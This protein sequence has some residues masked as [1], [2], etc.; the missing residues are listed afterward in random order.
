MQFRAL[1]KSGFEVPVVSF[2]AWAIGGWM[3]GGADDDDAVRAI[4]RGIDLGITCIDTAPMY[5][6]G[7]SERLV[8]KAIAGRRDE[9]IVATKCGLRWDLEEGEFFFKTAYPDGTPT[10]AYKNLRPDSIRHECEQS[11]ERLGVDMIDLYQ[12]HW[13]EKGANLEDT[14][15]ALN[16][17]QAE[18]K[19]RAFGVSNFTPEM[20]AECLR[21]G[22]IVSDQPPYSPLRRD[23][24]RDVLPF[25]AENDLAVLV[26][27]PLD[28]GLMTGKVTLDREFPEGDLRR[29]HPLFKQEN[30]KRI[31]AM[32]DQ[33]RPVAEGHGATLAQTML[34]WVIAQRGVTTALVGAR[35]ERQVEENA[36]AGDLRLA[37]DELALIRGLIEGFEPAP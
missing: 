37:D 11:L 12:V 24:E 36:K 10:K 30:R 2:G 34:A 31:L 16:E 9:V 26:Y 25:C 3:W 23:A 21:H 13:P 33:V 5:G 18:G 1:G 19:I 8:G 35:D 17:L 27:S 28:Q 15:G 6:M 20:M 29:N 14:V 22:E 7:H 32:L 4:R